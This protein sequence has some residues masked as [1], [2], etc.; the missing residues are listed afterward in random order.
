MPKLIAVIAFLSAMT[1]SV[2]AFDVAKCNQH[3]LKPA[4]GK[5]ISARSIA[6]TD[7]IIRAAGTKSDKPNSVMRD[8]ARRFTAHDPH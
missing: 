2:F 6:R 4:V 3:A 1:S 7:A 5:G 8:E